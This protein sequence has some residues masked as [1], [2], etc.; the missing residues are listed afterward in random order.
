MRMSGWDAGAPLAR[1][2][3]GYARAGVGRPRRP[4]GQS[5]SALASGQFTGLRD[6]HRSRSGTV[7]LRTWTVRAKIRLGGKKGRKTIRGGSNGEARSIRWPVGRGEI[8]RHGNGDSK[9]SLVVF[10]DCRTPTRTESALS[11][12][13][14]AGGGRRLIFRRFSA[15]RELRDGGSPASFVGAAADAACLQRAKKTGDPEEARRAVGL[16][17]RQ[18]QVLGS[19]FSVGV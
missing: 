19:G 15:D 3:S 6:S 8:S 18:I 2:R 17:G 9:P 16:Q 5:Q 14:S 10:A 12:S 7:C 4:V 11:F 1:A 13:V